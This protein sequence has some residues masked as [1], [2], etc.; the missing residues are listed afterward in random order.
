MNL[1]LSRDFRNMDTY[2]RD[3]SKYKFLALGVNPDGEQAF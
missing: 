3:I 1:G 2:L